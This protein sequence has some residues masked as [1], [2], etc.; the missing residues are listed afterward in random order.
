MVIRRLSIGPAAKPGAAGNPT[1]N[2]WDSG[3]D[4]K[5]FPVG[6]VAIPPNTAVTLDPI[7]YALDQTE[8]LIVAFDTAAYA[9]VPKQGSLTGPK[10]F[11]K[12]STAEA[13][14][15]KRTAGYTTANDAVVLIEKIEVGN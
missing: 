2:E 8:D 12:A 5:E 14:L 6:G 3:P 11:T 4:L 9:N 13:G 1:P 10:V 15:P 7:D